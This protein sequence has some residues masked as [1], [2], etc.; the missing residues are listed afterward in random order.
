MF[1]ASVANEIASYI[2]SLALKIAYTV[3]A[4]TPV[5]GVQHDSESHQ[6]L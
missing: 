1:F 3:S 5:Q 6:W 4:I 2:A